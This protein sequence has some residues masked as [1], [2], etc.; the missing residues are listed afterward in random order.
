MFRL[1]AFANEW[2]RR[3]VHRTHHSR[4][5]RSQFTP[6]A[7]R[8][9]EGSRREARRL[10]NFKTIGPEHML[11]A[12]IVEPEGLGVEVLTAMVGN[13]ERVRAAVVDALDSP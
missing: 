11:L 12:L 6:S 5:R 3:R 2:S 9:L 4:I 10:A 13:P 1:P 7:K 8:V